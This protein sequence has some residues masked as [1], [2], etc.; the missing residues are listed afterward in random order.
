MQGSSRWYLLKQNAF[1]F[2]S[3]DEATQMQRLHLEII[4]QPNYIATAVILLAVT[5]H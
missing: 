5:I 4:I 1:M 3:L 2:P